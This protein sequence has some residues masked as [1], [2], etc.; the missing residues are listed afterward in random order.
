MKPIRFFIV[1]VPKATNDT[2][3]IAGQEMYLYYRFN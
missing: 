2:I 3:E 1:K